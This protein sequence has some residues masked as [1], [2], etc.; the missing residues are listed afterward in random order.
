MVLAK[1]GH[2]KKELGVRLQR[3]R[4][5]DAESASETTLFC[6]ALR[7]QIDDLEAALYINS[8][9]SSSA[10]TTTAPASSS[11]AATSSRRSSRR[12]RRQRKRR[13]TATPTARPPSE[14]EAY[15]RLGMV[16][17]VVVHKGRRRTRRRAGYG[18]VVRHEGEGGARARAR[19]KPAAPADVEEGKVAPAA[20][21]RA[22]ATSFN[23]VGCHPVRGA[24]RAGASRAGAADD[25]GRDAAATR[26][27]QAAASDGDGPRGDHLA[28]TGTDTEQALP[29]WRRRRDGRCRRRECRPR[30]HFCRHDGDR[31]MI[32]SLARAEAV[33][34][35]RAGG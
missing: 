26:T 27:G 20:A 18:G 14:Y 25:A 11:S 10:P 24:S 8:G 32:C 12:S 22:P 29:R 15:L 30:R 33:L 1:L 16:W 5:R 35:W 31:P 23:S 6:E 28:A 17:P 3:S 21:A 2:L 34:N 13:R 7:G 4:Q 19:A 9:R